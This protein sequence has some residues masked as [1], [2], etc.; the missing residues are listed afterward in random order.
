MRV[1]TTKK[2]IKQSWL[3]PALRVSFPRL[4]VT[5]ACGSMAATTLSHCTCQSG[6][7][8]PR[9]ISFLMLGILRNDI[10]VFETDGRT[11][12]FY[13]Q[14]TM[15]VKSGQTGSPMDSLI[16][17]RQSYFY[18]IVFSSFSSGRQVGYR[19]PV[20]KE[21]VFWHLMWRAVI[22]GTCFPP[23]PLHCTSTLTI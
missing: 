2:L 16:S 22:S 12:G 10:D 21:I 3:T 11:D 13:A 8:L 23:P 17:P 4:Q 15:L 5:Y 20:N 18:Q 19:L 1:H 14:S 9:L 6:Q 7:R